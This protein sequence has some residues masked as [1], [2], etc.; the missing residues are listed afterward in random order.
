MLKIKAFLSFRIYSNKKLIEK[1]NYEKALLHRKNQVQL[2]SLRAWLAYM[3]RRK[4]KYNNREILY[5]TI[6]KV[7]NENLMAR[8]FDYL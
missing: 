8:F 5:N 4:T 6:Q 1:T 2:K 3:I 7:D